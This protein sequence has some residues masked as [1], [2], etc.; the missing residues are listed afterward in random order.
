MLDDKPA[1]IRFG[2]FK[3]QATRRR[4][5][6]RGQPEWYWVLRLRRA[7]EDQKRSL[8]WCR[9][10]DQASDLA[11]DA[12]QAWR[13]HE[14]S[15]CVDAGSALLTTSVEAYFETVPTLPGLRPNT[16]RLRQ[17]AARN[18]LD[19]ARFE[20]PRLT[21]AE[22]QP[23]HGNAYANWLLSHGYARSTINQ[24]LIGARVYVRWARRDWGV[25]DLQFPR[26]PSDRKQLRIPSAAEIEAVV[27]C[28]DPQLA[29]LLTVM[30]YT[31]VRIGEALSRHGADVDLRG[32]RMR[33]DA[34]GS[35]R[36]KTRDS[37]RVVGLS[38]DCVE[39]IEAMVPE[40]NLPIWPS[41]TKSAIRDYTARLDRAVESAG[42][43]K[44]TF[45]DLRRH[46]S[47]RLRR[48]KVGVRVYQ[49]AMGHSAVTAMK[50][51]QEPTIGEVLDAFASVPE[52]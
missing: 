10:A 33:I 22:L 6:E 42:V 29:S 9:D 36:P 37:Y 31:G 19:W 21:C 1:P 34:R 27:A 24:L 30:A 32:K 45:H 5:G 26:L 47:D 23:R 44:L 16:I 13:D 46:V 40:R 11:L 18:L 51:Y 15:Q 48:A 35:W 14:Q 2:T 39:A 52:S 4:I 8:G 49:A 3:I 28:S 7:G 17:Y 50:E 20:V 38:P 25:P 12:I 41:H 43:P